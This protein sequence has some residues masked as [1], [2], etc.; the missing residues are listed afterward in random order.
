MAF[1]LIETLIV[2]LLLGIISVTALV[3]LSGVSDQARVSA[4]A[5][6][7]LDLDALAR[8]DAQRFG[9]CSI[10]LEG[11]D[12]RVRRGGNT[13][14]SRRVAVDAIT[15]RR[16]TEDAEG[17]EV[18]IDR[19]GRSPDYRFTVRVGAIQETWSIA[20][21]TGWAEQATVDGTRP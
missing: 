10:G 18:L 4:A 7:L 15:L 11:P 9:S 21:L 19:L 1:T 16:G 12:I 14:S 8:V 13:I 5:R 3:S 20:G 2:V 6:N 17:A